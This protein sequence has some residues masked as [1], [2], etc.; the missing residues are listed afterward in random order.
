MCGIAGLWRRSGGNA[1][2]TAQRMTSRIVHRGP[3]DA[4]VWEDSAA[5]V[6]LGF[7]RLAIIDLTP[8]G[9]QPMHSASGRYTIV[10]NGEVYNFEA[11][12]AELESAGRAPNWRGHSDTEVML[13]AIEAWGL[14][15][16]L[17]RFVGMF[18]IAL[19]DSIERQLHLVRDRIGVKPLYFAPAANALLFGSE[20]KAMTVAEEFPHAINRDAV[21]QYTRYGYVPTPYSIYENVWK[22]RP[23][24]IVTIDGRGRTSEREYWSVRDVITAAQQAPFTGSDAEAIAEVERLAA[25]SVRLRM[26]SD[27]PLGV[28]LS[29]GIDSSLVAALMQSQSSVP[30]KTFTIGFTEREYNEAEHAAAVARHLRTDHT[31]LYVTPEDAMNVIPSLPDIYDEPFADSSQIPTYLVSKLAREK[32]TVSLSGDGGDEFFGG[33]TRYV[34][35]RQLWQRIASVPRPIRPVISGAMKMLPMSAWNRLLSPTRRFV[36]KRLRRDRAGER[37]HKFA[38]ALRSHD[39]D[40]LYYEIVT[41]WN[42]LVEGAKPLNIPVSDRS[43]WPQ[44]ADYTERMMFFDQISYLPD[45][46]LVKVDRASMAVSLEAREPLLDHRLIEFAWRLP[47]SMKIRGGKGKWILRQILGRHVPVELFERPK[48]GFGIPI[49]HWLR[50]PLRGWAEDLLS[51]RRLR[52]DG[53]FRVSDVRA[54]WTDHVRGTGEWQ[55]YIWSV[56]MFQAWLDARRHDGSMHTEM[57]ASIDVNPPALSTS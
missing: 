53:F 7:R 55:Y 1:G 33:Y 54:K 27:V 35:G 30:V 6:A 13:A 29:G 47:L 31:E 56:L 52:E 5:G 3:D 24:T 8:A 9:H 19:W 45:D 49:D 15:D 16:A 2:E 38:R 12:R 39:P 23:G 34:L 28:F 4:G 10:F 57:P 11:M 43:S 17:R 51:E 26:V 44:I 36:P 21:A 46:I 50:G 37:I 41:L 40:W 48:M 18:A 20:L 22:V 42:D 32:V 25:D 14:D